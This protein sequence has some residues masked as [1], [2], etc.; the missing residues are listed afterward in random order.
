MNSAD[1]V[2]LLALEARKQC[3]A[4][5]GDPASE[6]RPEF[7]AISEQIPKMTDLAGRLDDPDPALRKV[8]ELES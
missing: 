7:M 5:S 3:E 8:E 4:V 6:L 1:F 2:K